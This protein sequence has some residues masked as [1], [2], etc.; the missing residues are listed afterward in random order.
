M[1]SGG[2]EDR[3]VYRALASLY[4]R[5][6]RWPEAEEAVAKMDSLSTRPEEK[7]EV[8]FLAGSIYEREKKFEKAEEMFRKVVTSD[9]NNAA[10]LNYLGYMLA[11]HNTR[12]EEALSYIRKAVQ[13]DPQ[14]GAYLD[15]LGW[16]YF[17]LGN[18]TQSEENLRKAVERL[19]NDPTVL[20][21]M[22]DV[23]QKTDRLKLATVYWERA[24]NEYNKSM[25]A[26]VEPADVAKVQKKLES[27][28]V[29]LAREG[30]S[31]AEAVKP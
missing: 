10:A 28:K 4:S 30:S 8:A 29:R 15:S 6:R 19:Q 27:A 13:L 7:D 24:L 25:A 20:E 23:L 16:V 9:P 31:K 21:H 22:G 18:Y 11:D 12:L 26:D 14:N 17:R 3:G 5:L 2:P 1:L